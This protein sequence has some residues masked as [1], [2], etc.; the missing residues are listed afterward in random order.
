MSIRDLERAWIDIDARAG[1]ALLPAH[2]AGDLDGE[3]AQLRHDDPLSS[4]TSANTIISGQPF[5]CC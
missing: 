4:V 2:P 1:L 3:L 5:C